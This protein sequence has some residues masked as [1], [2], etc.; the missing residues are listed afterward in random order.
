MNRLT[1]CFFYSDKSFTLQLADEIN[2][3]LYQLCKG[4]KFRIIKASDGQKKIA[5]NKKYAPSVSAVILFM[6]T[7]PLLPLGLFI[8]ACSRENLKQY[9]WVCQQ[10]EVEDKRR[11]EKEKIREHQKLGNTKNHLRNTKT[12]DL[13]DYSFCHGN[14]GGFLHSEPSLSL[15]SIN[16]EE[17]A[18]PSEVDEEEDDASKEQQA[19][20]KEGGVSVTIVNPEEETKKEVVDQESKPFE[21]LFGERK[22]FD[23]PSLIEDEECFS[24]PEAQ[25]E[26]ESQKS[27][28]TKVTEAAANFFS[29]W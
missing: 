27:A 1:T 2:E 18:S 29:W 3:P 26:S 16:E 15:S 4:R 19:G 24:D 12:S 21:D 20:R 17:E 6:L 28:W 13:D 8:K 10:Q 25:Q 22:E 7:F 11:D 14:G 5:T 23:L 9:K